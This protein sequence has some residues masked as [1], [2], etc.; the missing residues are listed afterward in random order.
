MSMSPAASPIVFIGDS[1]TA[2]DRRTGEPGD[3]GRG[4]V[5]LVDQKFS[6]HG[7][8]PPIVNAGVNGN[9]VRDLRERWGSDCL[10]LRPSLVSILVGVNDMWRRFDSGDPTSVSSFETDYRALLVSSRAEISCPLVLVEPFLLPVN[11][12]QVSWRE[13]LAGKQDVVHRLAEEFGA[14]VVPADSFLNS[15]ASSRRVGELAWDGV[16]PTDA[17]NELLA[18]LWWDV[19]MSSHPS[20]VGVGI[21]LA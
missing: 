8:R 19:V 20:L 15:A 11:H 12:E 16:H 10:R 3:L 2:A 4:F 1:V 9:R 14:L 21:D 6:L 7:Q 13:D 18:Q 17:G 5:K